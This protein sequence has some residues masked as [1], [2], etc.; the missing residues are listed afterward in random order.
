[1]DGQTPARWVYF[2]LTLLAFGSGEQK[3][4]LSA[5]AACQLICTFVFGISEKSHEVAHMYN[6]KA[7]STNSLPRRELGAV[8]CELVLQSWGR[9]FDPQLLKSFRCDF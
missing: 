2:K 3:K 5:F 8:V 6:V 1:M 7:T 4:Q 9:R